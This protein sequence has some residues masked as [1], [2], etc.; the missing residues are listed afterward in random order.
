MKKIFLWM[1]FSISF[2]STSL[3]GDLNLKEDEA[4]IK[5]NDWVV[6]VSVKRKE[7]LAFHREKN[8]PNANPMLDISCF[9]PNHTGNGF[10]MALANDEG[11]KTKHSDS[12]DVMV[13]VDDNPAM[14]SLWFPAG[15]RLESVKPRSL[16][17]EM[18]NSKE[19]HIRFREISGLNEYSYKLEGLVKVI[20]TME[21]VCG[22]NYDGS[23]N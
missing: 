11:Y 14:G 10:E 6:L 22:Y 12:V 5:I 18:M 23:E 21:Q 4:A 20:Q 17:K 9:L 1:I 7:A 15:T 16:I 3:A 19:F 13:S 8:K 2:I